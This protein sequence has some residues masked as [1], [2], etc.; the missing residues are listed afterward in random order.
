M[1][2]RTLFTTQLP[3]ALVKH[4][5]DMKKVGAKFQLHIKGAGSWNVDLTDSGPTCNEGE[6]PADVTL[7]IADADFQKLIKDPNSAMTYFFTG[8]L[9]VQGNQMLAMK[10]KDILTCLAK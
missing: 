1:D 6:G 7:S 2:A 9:K 10:L 8:K 5:T 4:A 3:E